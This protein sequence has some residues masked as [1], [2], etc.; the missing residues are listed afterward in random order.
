[1]AGKTDIEWSEASWNPLRGCS[2][3]TPGCQTCYAETTAAR[4]ISMDRGRGVPE[5]LGS[6]DGLLARG[7]QWNGTIREATNVLDQ[8]LRWTTGRL[9]FVNSMSDLFHENVSTETLDRIFAVMLACEAFG[10]RKHI[11]QVLTKRAER[12]LQYLQSRSDVEHLQAWAKAGDTF[13]NVKGR[14]DSFSQLVFDLAARERNEDGSASSE[15]PAIPWGYT[16]NLYPLPNLWLGV[17]VENQAC[18]EARVPLLMRSP[19]AVRWISAEPLLGSV[20]LSAWLEIGSLAS[21]LGLSNPGIDWVVVGGESGDKARP[22][23][24]AWARGLRDQCAAATVPFLFKQWGRWFTKAYT[25]SD[26]KA[27]FRE[28]TSYQQW[29]NKAQ[30]WVNGGICLDKHG[31][32]LRNGADMA[33]ARDADGFP[34]IVMHSVGKRNSGRELDG[35][36]HDEYPPNHL[37][38]A[39][40][41]DADKEN[42]A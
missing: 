7:G 36:L 6:Y 20:D 42:C 27:V 2:R 40:G 37:R 10:D 16:K 11:F 21:E 24:P 32:E 12:M 18:A 39:P 38:G 1:M 5:G 4:I 22:M 31:V 35:K 28:F 14:A 29:I 9:I 19:A 13:I 23:H 26:R 17:S 41:L 8:P 15:G 25:M 33:R 30:T 3:L 34:V